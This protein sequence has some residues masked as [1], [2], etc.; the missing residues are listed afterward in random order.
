ML[1]EI[2]I[3]LSFSNLVDGPNINVVFAMIQPN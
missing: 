3:Y 2:M 1:F